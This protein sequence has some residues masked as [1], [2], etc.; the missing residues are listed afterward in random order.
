MAVIEMGRSTRDAYNSQNTVFN[1][2][3]TLRKYNY[4]SLKKWFNCFLSP[5]FK[6]RE[7]SC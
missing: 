6:D 4:S 7:W 5:A 3:L 1:F 2:K